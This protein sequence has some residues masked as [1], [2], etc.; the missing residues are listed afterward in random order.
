MTVGEVCRRD[1]IIAKAETPLVEAVALMKSY[2]VGDLVVVEGRGGRRMPI[3]ILT[4]RDVALSIANHAARIAHLRVSDLMKQNPITAQEG[5]SLHDAL[6]KMQANG[7]R[8]LPVVD[9]T[10]ELQG[11]LTL[12]DLVELLSEELADLAKRV[13]REQWRERLHQIEA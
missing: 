10:G 13:L 3:G 8:R 1:V 9:L 7:I 11:I 12:D 5:D 4:D 2:H 6:K